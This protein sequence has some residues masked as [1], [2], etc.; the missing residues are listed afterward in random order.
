MIPRRPLFP[1][2]PAE[3]ILFLWVILGFTLYVW[4]YRDVIPA[5][6]KV[7]FST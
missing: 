1:M 2:R 5:V 4:Q 6:F 7:L 3:A